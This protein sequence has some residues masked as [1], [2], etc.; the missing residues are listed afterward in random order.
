MSFRDVAI[1]DLKSKFERKRIIVESRCCTMPG[2]NELITFFKGP[3]HD[4]YC[5]EHQVAQVQYG[6]YG[7]TGREHT[8]HRSDVCE[9]CGQDVNEDPRWQ[10]CK[11]YFDADLDDIQ[12]HEVK[13]RYNHGDHDFRKADGGSNSKENT[14]AYCSFCHWYKTV[15]NNDGRKGELHE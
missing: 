3:G 5:R 12:K 6:G 13:R 15:L 2:C 10:K 7:R 9:C 4:L 1:D 8:F 14:N 11:D